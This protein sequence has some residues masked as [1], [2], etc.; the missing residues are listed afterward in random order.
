MAT[1]GDVA[2]RLV[3]GL[4]LGLAVCG[5]MAAPA[6]AGTVTSGGGKIVFRAPGSAVNHLRVS[7]SSSDIRFTDGRARII[8][9]HGCT[10]VTTHTAT[11]PAAGVGELRMGMG[12]DNDR[13]ILGAALAL[14]S[15]DVH[16]GGGNDSIV[17]E[18]PAMH[19]FGDAGADLLRG[20]PFL[21]G[22]VLYGGSGDDVLRG[23][24]GP[25]V[26]IGNHGDDRLAGGVGADDLIGGRGDDSLQGKVGND[27][28]HGSPGDDTLVDVAGD[29]SLFGGADPDLLDA[30]DGEPGDFLDGGP[31]PDFACRASFGDAVVRCK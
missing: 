19:A 15:I 10:S 29:D 8:A 5:V 20:S 14:A 17:S 2:A 23:S 11:C 13:V 31:G 28:L 26:L 1:V 16:G 12:R 27:A 4:A 30:R 25:D 24:N 3:L 9:G 22:D 6:F 7:R 21:K 18:Q